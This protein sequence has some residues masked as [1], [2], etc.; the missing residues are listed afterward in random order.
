MPDNYVTRERYTGL[1]TV[2]GQLVPQRGAVPDDELVQITPD[3]GEAVRNGGG[4]RGGKV[5]RS[6]HVIGEHGPC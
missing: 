2:D 1:A 5:K 3:D 6:S 4:R